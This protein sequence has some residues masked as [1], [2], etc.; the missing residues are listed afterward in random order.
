[1]AFARRKTETPI[2]SLETKLASLVARRQELDAKLGDAAGEM[3]TALDQRRQSLLDSD[4]S[5]EVAAARRDAAVRNARDRHSSLVDALSLLGEQIVAAEIELKKA[6]AHAE[7]QGSADALEAKANT[8]DAVSAKA[9]AAD[10]ETLE[11]LDQ[12]VDLL[13]GVAP[14]FQTKVHE[15]YSALPIAYARLLADARSRAAALRAGTA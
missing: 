8:F 2:D 5:D 12:L 7:R 11:A 9:M 15:L 4:L 1:M 13:P 10:A 14:H 6:R 3:A